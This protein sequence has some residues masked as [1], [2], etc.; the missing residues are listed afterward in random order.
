MSLYGINAYTSNSYYSSLLSGKNQSLA[1]SL[2]SFNKNAS[3][4]NL[5]SMLNAVKVD[6]NTDLHT[7]AR[8][9]DLVRSRKFQNNLTE[10]LKKQFESDSKTATSEDELKLAENAKN[11]SS[12]AG[13]LAYNGSSIKEPDQMIAAVKDFTE[14][15][16]ATLDGLQKTDS[17]NAL[18]KGVSL[19][20]TTKAYARA[21]SRVGIVV[22]SDN[23]LTVNE[24]NVK[25]ATAENFRSLFSGNYSYANKVADKAS[26]I[27][28]AADLK[29]QVTY[30]VKGNLDYYNK[31][32]ASMIFD[33]KI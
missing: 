3:N 23:R 12:Y 10:E 16:N 18:E 28:R 4:S 29:A 32:A 8:T 7:L 1:D 20:N 27:S 5:S 30:N 33:D 25:K 26:Y 24:E 21:L 9:V 22:G 19:V 2:S 17:L 13:A 14:S 31:M 6:G 15:Y 11:L